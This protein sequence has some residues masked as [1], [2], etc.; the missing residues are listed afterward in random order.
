MYMVLVLNPNK[1]H[2]FNLIFP[3]QFKIHVSEMQIA[4]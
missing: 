2:V 3:L 4:H 1:N